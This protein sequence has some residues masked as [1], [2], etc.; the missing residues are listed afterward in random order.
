MG[1]TMRSE[2]AADTRRRQNQI[3]K[4]LTDYGFP[5]EFADVIAE[6]TGTP[7]TAGRMLDYLR[8]C[9]PRREEDV[10]DELLGIY[11]DRDQYVKKQIGKKNTLGSV[12]GSLT[13]L[14]LK[15]IRIDW[16]F[17]EDSYVRRIPA[18]AGLDS[19]TF[20]GNLTFFVGEN[21]SGKS[22]LLEAIAIACGFNPEGGTKNYDFH[23]YDDYSGLARSLHCIAGPKPQ[24]GFFLRAESFYNVASTA[25]MKYNDDGRMTDYHSRSHGES[26]LEFIQQGA[27]KGLYLLDEPEAALSPQRQLTLLIHLKRMAEAG[28]QYIIISHSPILL[29]IPGAK[30]LSFDDGHVHEISYEETESYR[31]TKMF[32]EN[33]EYFLDR[34]L[35]ETEDEVPQD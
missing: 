5:A 31:I 8:N 23:T 33:R 19:L 13:G 15:G 32:L 17:V 11:E 6:R 24:W 30:I 28:S 14:F 26:F 21:G 4:I 2:Q 10:V 7:Y 9:R 27:E 22:T 18:L 1:H 12:P 34:L 20:S 25:M 29:G 16:D 35:T 3:R